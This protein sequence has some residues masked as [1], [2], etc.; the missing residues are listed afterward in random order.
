MVSA[1]QLQMHPIKQLGA[2]KGL[3]VL[4]DDGQVELVDHA[5]VDGVVKELLEVALA[6]GLALLGKQT[7]LG[8]YPTGS[9]NRV[10]AIYQLPIPLETPLS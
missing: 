2:D 5:L 6:D 1:G 8:E 3:N 4:A 9:L 7:L 10:A